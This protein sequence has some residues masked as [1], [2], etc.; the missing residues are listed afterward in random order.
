[1]GWR[2]WYPIG[3]GVNRRRKVLDRREARGG[4]RQIRLPPLELSVLAEST[5]QTCDDGA[6]DQRN[7][8]D[9]NYQADPKSGRLPP[10][11]RSISDAGCDVRGRTMR[12]MIIAAVIA[13]AAAAAAAEEKPVQLKQAP[14][15]DKVEANCGACHSLDYVPMNSPFLNAAG[16]DA[17]VAKMINAFGAP[18]D[19]ADAKIISDYLK[20]NY[21]AVPERSNLHSDLSL[22][23]SQTGQTIAP[24]TPNQTSNLGRTS[25]RIRPGIAVTHHQSG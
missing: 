10:Q 7:R 19:P 22:T 23:G 21:S 18:I 8:S 14:G 2:L 1:M 6:C 12:S 16:W 11:R 4:S 25:D 13:L 3:R 24:K 9:A 17:E 15:L 5:R 20:N